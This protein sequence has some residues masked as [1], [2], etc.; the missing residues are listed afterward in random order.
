M[1]DAMT[2][3]VRLV[4]RLRA[5]FKTP[6]PPDSPSRFSI[7]NLTSHAQLATHVEVARTSAQRSKGLLGRNG[8]AAGEGLWIV[9]CESVHTFGMRFAIDL[10]YL[11][12]QRRIKKIR[13]AVP[14]WRISACL[15]AHS[16]LELAAGSVREGEARLGDTLEFIPVDTPQKR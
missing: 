13:R 4:V 7:V 10:V 3:I 15:T 16:V 14:P 12:R 1:R 11:D 5:A 2:L 6:P 8:L 9:P